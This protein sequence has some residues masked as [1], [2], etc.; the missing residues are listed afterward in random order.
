MEGNIYQFPG[1]KENPPIQK[2]DSQVSAEVIQ[3]FPNKEEKTPESFE[4]NGV[5]LSALRNKVT[6]VTEKYPFLMG[7]GLLQE[8]E[9]ATSKFTR[10]EIIRI[11]NSFHPDALKDVEA[12]M[13]K[14]LINRI[15]QR[16]TDE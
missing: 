13:Y 8:A 10:N 14:V 1:K 15:E 11:I 2:E 16:F 12:P 4:V 9:E 6:E 5:V 3:L 7:S